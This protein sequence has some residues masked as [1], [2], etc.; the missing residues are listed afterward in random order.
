MV[1]SLNHP[2]QYPLVI[3]SYE[4]EIKAQVFER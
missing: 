4:L 1:L 2:A 3:A